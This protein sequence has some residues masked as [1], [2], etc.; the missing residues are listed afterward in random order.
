MIIILSKAKL[1][2]RLTVRK[3]TTI[4]GDFANAWYT[5]LMG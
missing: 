1:F 5:I 4:E 3:S 2:L